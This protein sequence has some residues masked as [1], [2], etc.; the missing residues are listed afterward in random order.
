MKVVETYEEV[1]DFFAE[2]LKEN[3]IIDGEVDYT[4]VDEWL[5]F[6]ITNIMDIL[7]E[8][9]VR[10]KEFSWQYGEKEEVD[11]NPK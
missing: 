1:F 6:V 2:D 8:I 5:Q 11:V 10:I 3:C 9:G 7:D 4:L